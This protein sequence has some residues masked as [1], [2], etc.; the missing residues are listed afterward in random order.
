MGLSEPV[1]CHV[2]LVDG[3]S[4]YAL[5]DAGS[6]GE[7]S[8]SAIESAMRLHGLDPDRLSTLLLTHWHFDH[9]QGANDIVARFGCRVFAPAGER[10]FIENGRS[11]LQP[12]PIDASV[13]HG[14]DITIG[15]L[16]LM[17]YT[18]PGHSE[19]TT[20]YLLATPDTRALLCGDV[21]FANGVIGLINYPGSDLQQ[22]RDHIDRLQGLAVDAL[23][24]GHGGLLDRFDS[25]ALSAPVY[26][27]VTWLVWRP[28]G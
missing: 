8:V 18:V 11:G 21:V 25:L 5:I 22:Y 17:A 23:L 6:G 16:E 27:F 12:C 7:P 15:N 9:A 28:G 2:Y 10:A 20:A 19:A 24:P 13:E 4:E 3:G 14:D 26:F 1:D